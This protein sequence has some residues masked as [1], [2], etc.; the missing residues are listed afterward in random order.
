MNRKHVKMFICIIILV[1]F[2]LPL[3]SMAAPPA[4]DDFDNATLI[5]MLPFNDE[6]ITIEAT[7]SYDDPY[8]CSNNG[9]V[10]YAFT[11][12]TD[13]KIEANTFGSDYYN[14]I[15]VYTG[16][17]GN[18]CLVPDTCNY[19][20]KVRF[21]AIEGTT[22]YFL[23][24]Y[25]CGYG[26]SG[27]GY[28]MFSVR[29]ILPPVNDDFADAIIIN[30]LPFSYNEEIGGASLQTGEPI[31]SCLYDRLIGSIWFVFTATEDISLAARVEYWSMI[32]VYTGNSLDNLMEI[33]CRYSNY[34]L[35]TFKLNKGITYYFQVGIFDLGG[36]LRFNLGVAPPP[37]V[38]FNFYPDP[39]SFFDTVQF[40]DSSYD[41]ANK[42]IES[43]LWDLGDGTTATEC[44][45]NHRYAMDGSY[46]VKLTV[47]TFDGRTGSTSKII[48]VETHDVA[49]TRITAPQAASAGQTRQ[50]FVDINNKGYPET[51]EVMI[52]KST[53]NGFQDFGTLIQ[54]VPVNQSNKTTRFS[55]RYTFT[56]E[57][58]II[59][60]VTFKATAN[61]QYIR[62]ALPGDN[63]AIASPTKVN[64]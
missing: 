39:P 15:S 12:T 37:K 1:V 59:G 56:N 46:T 41:P 43:W 4:N 19:A 21:R 63:E 58:A 35:L 2:T 17:R 11:P 36:Q 64:N 16:R 44:C 54:F 26:G 27:G 8:D 28:L 38:Y 50:I 62:D 45:P 3:I 33:D 60:K 53:P 52:S 23:I 9:S 5:E 24:S 13:M 6:I 22:Y 42:G 31:P 47:T 57:D 10:W 20:V 48:R 40:Y 55:F 30:A 34:D 7:S 29:E 14:V 49:I 32:T 25:C 18:L 61:I 51:V